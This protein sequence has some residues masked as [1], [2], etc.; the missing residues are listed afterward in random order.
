MDGWL[1]MFLVLQY[2][3]QGGYVLPGVCLSVCL[4]ACLSYG[5]FT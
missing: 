3:R 5:N 1:R 2:L 4:S